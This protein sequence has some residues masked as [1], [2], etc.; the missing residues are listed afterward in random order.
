MQ[1]DV[2]ASCKVG[3]HHSALQ[4][5]PRV[6]PVHGEVHLHSGPASVQGHVWGVVPTPRQRAHTGGG[7]A[8]GRAGCCNRAQDL[9]QLGGSPT[10]TTLLPTTP[11]QASAHMTAG[12]FVWRPNR[13]HTLPQRLHMGV[14]GATDAVSLPGNGPLCQQRV[15]RLESS[16]ADQRCACLCVRVCVSR[17]GGGCKHRSQ[18]QCFFRQHKA[19]QDTSKT[20]L[21]GCHGGVL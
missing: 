12:F 17:G 15:C 20:R 13:R 1:I 9:G 10:P 2:V 14:A 5:A 19:Q 6:P 7:G 8:Q 18:G 4:G 16:L 3:H 21:M 11:S